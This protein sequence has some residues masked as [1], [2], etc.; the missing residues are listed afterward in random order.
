[1][2]KQDFKSEYFYMEANRSGS[3]N[4][5]PSYYC[6][7]LVITHSGDRPH[8]RSRQPNVSLTDI[9]KLQILNIPFL[10][11]LSHIPVF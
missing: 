9:G 1:M 10:G 8:K 11:P 7:L 6:A 5:S 3:L 2:G 4:T